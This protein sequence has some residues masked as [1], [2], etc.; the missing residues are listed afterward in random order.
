M[1]IAIDYDGTY[2]ADPEMWQAIV[3]MM[4][5]CGH[6]VICATMRYEHEPVNPAPPCMVWYTGRKA[7]AKFLAG[8]GIRPDIWIDDDPRFILG[9]SAT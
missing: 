6:E 5:R 8:L 7:K 3:L 2:T 1:I 9:D 4:R